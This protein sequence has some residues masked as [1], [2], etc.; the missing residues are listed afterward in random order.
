MPNRH[1]I[2]RTV[3]INDIDTFVVDLF[4]NDKLVESRAL[5]GKSVHYANDVSENWDTGI[6]KLGETTQ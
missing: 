1:S 5:P 2:I 4:E 6:I 3:K